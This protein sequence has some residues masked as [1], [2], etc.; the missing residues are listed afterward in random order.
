MLK[1]FH[2]DIQMD[3]WKYRVATKNLIWQSK[4]TILKV[5]VSKMLFLEA[6]LLCN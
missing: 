3:I 5:T 6:Q 1:T 4:P 2:M